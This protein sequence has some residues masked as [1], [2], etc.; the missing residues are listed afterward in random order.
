M[1]PLMVS[2][3]LLKEGAHSR[4]RVLRAGGDATGSEMVRALG[5]KAQ[6]A[7]KPQMVG[8]PFWHRIVDSGQ[9]VLWG[10]RS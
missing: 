7:E 9:S 4:H 1:T 8:E 3:P 6:G 5:V 2:W 10:H